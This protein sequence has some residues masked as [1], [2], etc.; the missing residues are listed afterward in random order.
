MMLNSETS[1]VATAKFNFNKANGGS[2]AIS[3]P[4]PIDNII[5]AQAESFADYYT[6]AATIGGGVTFKNLVH[7]KTN[8]I[9]Y[10]R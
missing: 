3:I 4:S 10:T 7:D 1:I 2:K 6:E 9:T 5:N 8:R